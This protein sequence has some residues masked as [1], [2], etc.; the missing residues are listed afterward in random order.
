MS[1]C[2]HIDS[3]FPAKIVKFRVYERDFWAPKVEIFTESYK[4]NF[5]NF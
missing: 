3:H 5:T 2:L 1:I 4:K